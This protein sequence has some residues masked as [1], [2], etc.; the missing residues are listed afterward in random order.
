M[1]WVMKWLF[2]LFIVVCLVVGFFGFLGYKWLEQVDADT[3][4]AHKMRAQGYGI[5]HSTVWEAT[6]C[7]R[8]DFDMDKQVVVR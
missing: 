3:Q 8:G 7:K 1:F 4:L 6:A 2:R 5:C